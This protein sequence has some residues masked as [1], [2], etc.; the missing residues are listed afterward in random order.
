MSQ[1]FWVKLFNFFHFY[2]L[3]SVVCHSLFRFLSFFDMFR[4]VEQ[5][6]SAFFS[7][8]HSV[9]EQLG[10]RNSFSRTATSIFVIVN[11]FVC[12]FDWDQFIFIWKVCVLEIQVFGNPTVNLEATVLRSKLGPV[13]IVKVLRHL[14]FSL[15]LSF[16][17]R[18]STERGLSYLHHVCFWLMAYEILIVFFASWFSGLRFGLT[19]CGGSVVFGRLFDFV[20]VSNV[21]QAAMRNK[22]YSWSIHRFNFGLQN[23]LQNFGRLFFLIQFAFESG[24][25]WA[26]TR[27]NTFESL[28]LCKL[29]PVVR[30][31]ILMSLV[32]IWISVH[33]KLGLLKSCFAVGVVLIIWKNSRNH[34]RFPETEDLWE[35]SGSVTDSTLAVWVVLRLETADGLFKRHAWAEYFSVWGNG[36]EVAFNSLLAVAVFTSSETCQSRCVFWTGVHTKRRSCGGLGVAFYDLRVREGWLDVFETELCVRSDLIVKHW[37]VRWSLIFLVF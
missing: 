32:L 34:A 37:Q 19:T 12:V 18:E 6:F 13:H 8:L 22:S 15:L 26:S 21:W 3:C 5:V 31:E 1:L 9:F 27:F 4:R 10:S 25:N 23:R 36:S 24:G 16:Y 20:G 30:R 11:V 7:S 2:V 17:F 28:L 29:K 35:A 33:V 14:I